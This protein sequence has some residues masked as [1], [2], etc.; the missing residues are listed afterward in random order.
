[1]R[2]WSRV[3]NLYWILLYTPGCNFRNCPKKSNK[4]PKTPGSDRLLLP[5][6]AVL[7]LPCFFSFHP[8][9]CFGQD[10]WYMTVLT[11]STL[12][13]ILAF[14][15]RKWFPNIFESLY[16]HITSDL[17]VLYISNKLLI[18]YKEAF[19]KKYFIFCY[20]LKALKLF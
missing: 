10:I 12:W 16:L 14:K 20:I 11:D 15:M 2:E 18:G 5:S 4:E 19:N 8:K 1:M 9:F 6:P 3:W 17:I 13:T 7:I